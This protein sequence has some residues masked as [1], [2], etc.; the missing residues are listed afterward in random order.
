[1]IDLVK[2][3]EQVLADMKDNLRQRIV[4]DVLGLVIRSDEDNN[5][6]FSE[7]EVHLLAF[8]IKLQLGVY[9]VE[10]DEDKF[11]KVLCRGSSSMAQAVQITK[12]LIPDLPEEEEEEDHDEG[13]YDMFYMSVAG[14]V[15]NPVAGGTIAH[16]I[17]QSIVGRPSS[18][19]SDLSMSLHVARDP[20]RRAKPAVP[21]G[22]LL[23]SVKKPTLSP[24]REPAKERSW[25]EEALMMPPVVEAAPGTEEKEE[26]PSKGSMEAKRSERAK[27]RRRRKRDTVFH[28]W[29][30]LKTATNE[31]LDTFHEKSQ[32]S[33]DME[34]D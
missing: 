16:S 1:M 26:T 22:S 12:R 30:H 32:H 23:R 17:T 34:E 11:Q 25:L 10:F 20:S 6:L 3:N 2:E 18:R 29:D 19:S 4:Q 13:D 15:A 33:Q 31:A 8:K 21:A 7:K 28:A 27:P 14:S 24:S 9:G 5:G